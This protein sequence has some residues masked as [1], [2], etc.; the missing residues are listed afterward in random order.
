MGYNPPGIFEIID[1]FLKE[2][3]EQGGISGVSQGEDT[4]IM[5]DYEHPASLEGENDREVEV[6]Y[7]VKVTINVTEISRNDI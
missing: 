2:E 4:F 3:L 7:L 1:E 5:T 6:K